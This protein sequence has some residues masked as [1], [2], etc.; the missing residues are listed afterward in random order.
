MTDFVFTEIV[1][2]PPARVESAALGV[3][4]STGLVQADVGKAVKLAANN[5]YVLTATTNDIE[6]LVSSVEP[7]PVNG[8]FGFGGVQK[9]GRA[10]VTVGATQSGAL[11]IGALVV[12]D[13]QAAVGTAGGCQVQVGTPVSHNWRVLRHVTGTGVTGDLVL[14]ERI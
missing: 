9:D 12:A 10:I 6:G 14:I 4:T 2:D 13:V 11:A 5:N 7:F 1:N 8:G 3:S